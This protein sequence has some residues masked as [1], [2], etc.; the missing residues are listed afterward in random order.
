MG[1]CSSVPQPPGAPPSAPPPE[2]S[3]EPH[4]PEFDALVEGGA[5][6]LA[7][8]DEE[9]FHEAGVW[10]PS[11]AEWL[12]TSNR[13]KAGTPETHVK[14]LAVHFPSGAVRRLE[15]LEAQIVMGN[16]GTTDFAGGAYL[17]SQGLGEHTG[18]LWH[19]DA[20]LSVGTRVG[21]PEGLVLNSL[22]DVVLHRASG[23]LLFTDPAYGIEVQGFRTTFH[24][25][26]AVWG[27]PADPEKAAHAASWAMLNECHDQP[28]GVLLSPEERVAYVTDVW[29][30]KWHNNPD[31]QLRNAAGA[32]GEQSRIHAFD[33]VHDA[34][35]GT[36]ALANARTFVDLREEPKPAE[37]Y[38]DGIKCDE[39][40]NVYA[41]CGGGVRVYAPSGHFLGRIAVKGGVANLCFGGDDGRTLLMLNETKAFT[42]RM[43]VRGALEVTQSLKRVQSKE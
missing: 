31:V 28:N 3:F 4:A 11:T 24:A 23:R 9:L 30:G 17:C 21:P 13:L 38:P 5:R 15:A 34:A 8:S 20:S 27:V 26:K 33:V 36:V 2:V 22:N 18:S 19:V 32:G 43:K 37:G 25:S 6:L 12:V 14:I 39:H 40:G 7:S 16:G 1:G 42:V 35:Q 29:S 41:G 10:I